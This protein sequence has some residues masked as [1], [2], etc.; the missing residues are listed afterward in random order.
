MF[1]EV[2]SS[3]LREPHTPVHLE[4]VIGIHV[5]PDAIRSVSQVI[6]PEG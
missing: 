5:W 2:P 3:L 1:Q 6:D 4:Q